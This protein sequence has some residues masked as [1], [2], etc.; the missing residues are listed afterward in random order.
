MRIKIPLKNDEAAV[1]HAPQ[2]VDAEIEAFAGPTRYGAEP[3]A[4]TPDEDVPDTSGVE[5][6]EPETKEVVDD[7]KI[8]LEDFS[9]ILPEAKNL[10]KKPETP[11]KKSAEVQK[12]DEAKKQIEEQGQKKQRDYTGFTE[13]EAA[14]LKK[15]SNE[16]FEFVSAR[17]KKASET[18]TTLRG[19]L[20][21]FTKKVD[22]LKAGKVQI[23]DNYYE[24]PDSVYLTP[25]A[26]GLNETIGLARSITNHWKQQSLAVETGAEWFD[27]VQDPKTGAISVAATPSATPQIG[28]KEWAQLKANI[29]EYTNHAQRQTFEFEGKLNNLVTGFKTKHEGLKSAV[30]AAEEK[31]MPMFKDPKSEDYKFVTAAHSELE[32]LGISK[33]NPAFS[34]LAKSIGLNILFTNLLKQMGSEQQIAASKASDVKKAGPTTQAINTGGDGSNRTKTAPSLEDFAKLGL[35]PI[36]L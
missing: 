12:V 3:S 33:S 28:T 19:E 25:E 17:L 5:K 10:L 26:R 20:A 1:A 7:K 15:T 27:L 36:K 30:A 22:E 6:A 16:A 34:M 21:E 2:N 29:S 23:P 24:N 18:E 9:K 32:K 14:I 4:K 35:S 13:Q 8:S 11:D 31:Y